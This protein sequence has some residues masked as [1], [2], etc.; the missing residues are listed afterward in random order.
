MEA[1]RTSTLPN[2]ARHADHVDPWLRLRRAVP[3][4]LQRALPT[5][6]AVV[7]GTLALLPSWRVHAPPPNAATGEGMARA[8]TVGLRLHADE[9]FKPVVMGPGADDDAAAAPFRALW[10]ARSEL[11]RFRDGRI[12]EAVVVTLPPAQRARTVPTLVA[13]LLARHFGVHLPDLLPSPAPATAAATGTTTT[14]IAASARAEGAVFLVDQLDEALA[15]PAGRCLVAPRAPVPPTADGKQPHLP[16][17][18]NIAFDGLARAIKVTYDTRT[19]SGGVSVCVYVCVCVCVCVSVCVALGRV[20][21][22]GRR[23]VCMRSCHAARDV[24]FC[25]NAA[26]CVP[27]ACLMRGW[28]WVAGAE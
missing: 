16:A 25:T 20:P 27:W 5:R 28:A 23:V 7:R 18:I 10:G 1:A 11:R 19:E 14:T 17:P 8:L 3:V 9:A 26:G 6:L 2:I 13:M 24:R 12:C 15:V 22:L 4:L 21:I